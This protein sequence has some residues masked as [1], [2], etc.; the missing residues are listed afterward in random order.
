MFDNWVR[1]VVLALFIISSAWAGIRIHIGQKADKQ[2][3]VAEIFS[4][5]VMFLIYMPDFFQQ[6]EIVIKLVG[7]GDK[8]IKIF[9]KT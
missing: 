3:L 5:I 9:G 2:L 8:S 4:I 6:G 1:I 7:N